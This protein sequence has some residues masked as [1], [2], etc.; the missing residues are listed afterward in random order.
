MGGFNA[1]L[2]VG[3][4][5]MGTALYEIQEM[6]TDNAQV[7]GPFQPVICRSCMDSVHHVDALISEYNQAPAKLGQRGQPNPDGKRWQR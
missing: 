1:Q 6:A 7:L 2:L 3:G 5:V 4:T